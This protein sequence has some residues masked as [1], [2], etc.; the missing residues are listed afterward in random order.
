M[1]LINKQLIYMIL[2]VILFPINVYCNDKNEK[3]NTKL[4]ANH[5]KLEYLYNEC[6][7]KNKG[8]DSSIEIAKKGLDLAILTDNIDFQIKFLKNLRGFYYKA[9]NFK[10]EIFYSEQLITILEKNKR[11]K[12]LSKAYLNL[13]YIYGRTFNYNKAFYYTNKLIELTKKTNDTVMQVRAY[14]NLGTVFLVLKDYKNAL[15]Y[16]NIGLEILKDLKRN[17]E[18]KASFHN[19]IAILYGN[20]KN[21]QIALEHQFKSLSF[22]EKGKNY[23]ELA[24]TLSNIGF[25]YLQLKKN[26]DALNYYYK[27]LTV[28]IKANDFLLIG[29]IYKNIGTAYFIMKKYDISFQYLI[30]AEHLG[31][32]YNNINVL[33]DTYEKLSDYYLIKK[34]Y[35]SS[36]KYYQLYKNMSDSLFLFQNNNKISE[37]K[38][39]F[40]TNEYE[41]E[42]KVLK[43]KKEYQALD[44]QKRKLLNKLFVSILVLFIVVVIFAFY[45]Y[46][47]SRKA[48]LLLANKNSL[49]SLQNKKLEEAN[50]TKDKFFSIIAK[51][52]KLPFFEMRSAILELYEKNDKLSPAE[53]KFIIEKL[54]ANSVYTSKL[55]ENLLIW[56][57]SQRGSIDINIREYNL[58]HIVNEVVNK[59]IDRAELKKQNVKINVSEGQKILADKYTFAI[60]L[61]SIFNNAIKFTPEYGN[62]EISSD[63][64]ENFVVIKI[65]DNGVGI[66]DERLNSLFDIGIDNVTLSTDKV[67][68]TGLGLL[69]CKDFMNKNNGDLIIESKIAIG[70][71]VT[72]KIVS[73]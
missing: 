35:N 24:L 48:N 55:L 50:N 63:L 33:K 51:D 62:I 43:L 44:I 31:L 7:D 19:N 34:D 26:N 22:L 68:G 10:M 45:R 69:I 41:K 1:S 28:S 47:Q 64:I 29:D 39:Q 13:T 42:N 9:Q 40:E 38:V 54:K 27:A 65:S 67:K 14:S 46:W 17:D 72:I 59:Y 73:A 60:V 12:D 57:R 61:E 56:S 71:T 53:Y 49:I 58:L 2:L 11:D 6:S 3:A 16:F 36:Y 20:N 15:K 8:L 5:Q 23:R 30:K 52:I 37:L 21:Y 18:L 4:T 70:T 32:E 66:D 25:T